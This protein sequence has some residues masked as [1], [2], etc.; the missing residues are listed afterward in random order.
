M[1]ANLCLVVICLCDGFFVS[2][3]EVIKLDVNVCVQVLELTRNA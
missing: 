1:P 2:V 3:F